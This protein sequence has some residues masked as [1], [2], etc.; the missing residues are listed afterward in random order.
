MSLTTNNNTI[1]IGFSPCPND[2][3]I[4]DALV[5]KKIDTTPFDFKYQLE[6]VE[7][8]NNWALE[9]KLPVTKISYNTFLKATDKYFL[10]DSGSALGNGVGPLLISTE[11]APEEYLLKESIRDARIAIPGKNTTANLLFSLAFPEAQHKT[12]IVFSEIEERVLN[13]EFDLG[14]I[15][16]E[17]RF[18]YYERGLQ[19]WMD[20]GDWW[21]KETG[22]AIPLGGI[23][24]RKDVPYEQAKQI[25]KLI[26]ESI[27]YSWDRYP[28]L[29]AFIK[30]HAQEMEESVMRKHI[31]LYVNQYTSSLGKDGRKAIDILFRLAKDNDLIPAFPSSVYL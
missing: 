23:C 16:H 15:I 5:Q 1:N 25:E 14:L 31:N 2:T 9:G 27:Q 17:G 26:K 21:E 22:S 3:F 13:G 28:E 10:L 12:E 19:K 11:K 20:M 4:F 29:S 24:V 6:D 8:L 30:E 7:T 18:T